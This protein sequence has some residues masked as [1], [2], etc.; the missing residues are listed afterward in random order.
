MDLYELR[1]T[2]EI[3]D[4]LK[5]KVS[6]QNDSDFFE[7][8]V[9]KKDRKFLDQYKHILKRV[10]SYTH[11]AEEW[12]KKE[13]A[14]IQRK[15]NAWRKKRDSLGRKIPRNFLYNIKEHKKITNCL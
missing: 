1:V 15:Y 5:I 9:P 10:F 3:L 11:S 13:V 14:S 7:Y 4:E 6:I 12:A 8:I 2:F